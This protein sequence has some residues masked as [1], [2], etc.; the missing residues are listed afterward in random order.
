MVTLSSVSVRCHHADVIPSTDVF[1]SGFVVQFCI[2]S[3]TVFCDRQFL[4]VAKYC[5]LLHREN[6]SFEVLSLH[7]P[8]VTADRR[9]L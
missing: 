1:P 5:T 3:Q 8:S 4:P 6:G 9:Q 7:L 2:C